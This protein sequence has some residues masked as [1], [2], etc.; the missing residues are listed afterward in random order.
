LLNRLSLMFRI[1]DLRKKILFTLLVIVI[2]RVGSFIILPYVNYDTVQRTLGNDAIFSEE[3][4]G[5][6]NYFALLAGGGLRNLAV[7]ALGIMPYITASIIMQLLGEIIPKIKSWKEEGPEGQKKVTQTTRY[8]TI[9]LALLQA[10]VLVYQLNQGQLYGQSFSTGEDSLVETFLVANMTTPKFLFMI[11][12]L[13]AGTAL[14]MWLGEL[15][16]AKGIGNGM[17]ILIFASVASS[18][19]FQFAALWTQGDKAQ[20]FVMAAIGVAMIAGVVFIES[21]QRRIPVQFAK[22]VVGR[23]MMG[24]QSTYIPIKVNTAGVVPVI[25]AQSLLLFPA[26]LAGLAN[27]DAIRDFV[28]K[29]FI[30]GQSWWYLVAEVLLIL[31]FAYFYTYI[32]FNP[33]QQAD[34]IRKQGGYIPGIKPGYD[35]E[36][37][38]TRIVNRIT[39]PGAMTIAFIAGLPIAVSIIWNI[40]QF[41]FGGTSMLIIVGVALE[42]MKQIDSQM[43]LRNYEGFLTK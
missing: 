37:Y 2:Y 9:L 5:L 19:P 11:L 42:T 28:D 35:T 6:L 8:V 10:S 29:H 43:S 20:F 36:R 4:G 34:I 33:S 31:G 24:G 41:P 15:I 23:K 39:L 18:I 27:N 3:G 1:E 26:L 16:T 30:N 14:L 21:G 7:F 40:T 38:L 32:A 25:F 12:T 17:S 22:R 13:V